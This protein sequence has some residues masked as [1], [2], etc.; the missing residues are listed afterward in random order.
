MAYINVILEAKQSITNLGFPEIISTLFYEKYGKTAP[1]LARWYKE[2][3]AYGSLADSKNW[4]YEISHTLTK[5]D[6]GQLTRYYQATKA[7]AAGTMTL[8]EYNKIRDRLDLR[9]YNPTEADTDEILRSLKTEIAEALFGEVF[10]SRNLIKAL[11]TNKVSIQPYSRL[12]FAQANQKFEEKTMFDDKPPIK[13][14]PNGW[15]WIDAGAKCDLVGSK[16]KNCG[17]TGVMSGDKNRTM[18]TLFDPSN[19]P[20]VVATY[21]PNEKRLSG[22]EGQAG[23][24]VKLEYVDYVLDLIKVLG[25]EF[26]AH[27]SKSKPLKLKYLLNPKSLIQIPGKSDFDEF[28]EI[29]LQSGESYYTNGYM[30]VSK[31]M[32]DALAIEP[33]NASLFD[34]L[35]KVFSY[36]FKDDITYDNP[37]FKYL[38]LHQAASMTALKESIKKND[39]RGAEKL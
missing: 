36:N 4:W 20:H 13:T 37:G 12:P 7:F 2:Y 18:L 17:S 19:N 38:T 31:N 9:D 34:K 39:P 14:Y 6:A 32:T 24:G 21:S 26:D 16:M 35:T 10:F 22:I 3:S 8:E 5:P 30:L 25:V 33:S 1:V 23:T 15:K 29:Q 11:G 27:N 28:F